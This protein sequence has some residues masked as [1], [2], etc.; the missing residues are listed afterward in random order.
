MLLSLFLFL[1]HSLT[2]ILSLHRIGIVAGDV[3]DGA[4][5]S[6]E[7]R[8]GGVGSCG[9]RVIVVSAFLNRLWA[10]GM[11]RYTIAFGQLFGRDWIILGR[12]EVD[13]GLGGEV[14]GLGD[15]G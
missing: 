14:F 10:G 1:S 7:R 8:F 13:G 12:G 4:F 3:E 6:D 5:D 11:V 15:V 2:V 9:R